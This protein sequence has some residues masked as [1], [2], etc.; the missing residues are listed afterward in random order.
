M[1][2]DIK[3][4]TINPKK[5][6]FKYF[7]GGRE[8]TDVNKIKYYKSLVIPPAWKDVSISSDPNKKILAIGLDDKFRKQYRY[9]KKYIQQQE[10]SKYKDR[11]IEFI[12]ELPYIRGGINKSLKKR[13]WDS[14]KVSAFV[15]NII[16]NCHLR[17][18]NDKYAKENDSYGITTLKGGHIDIKSNK[19]ILNFIGKKGVENY[20]EINEPSIIRLFKNYYN[21]F[22][23][24]QND[25]FFRYYGGNSGDEIFKINSSHINDYL[26]DYGDFSIKDFRTYSANEMLLKYYYNLYKFN[27]GLKDLSKNKLKQTN[28]KCIDKVSQHL[29]NTRAI[30]KKSYCSDYI[31][32]GF[33]D[34]PTEFITKVKKYM[35]KK[36][37]PYTG[38]QTALLNIFKDFKKEE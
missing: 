12:K 33:N 6:L 7:K 10:D 29:N 11:M 13:N 22:Q 14:E 25:D 19:I 5:H 3:R 2:L 16:D 31:I 20:S 36:V 26:K 15:I 23:P 4:K 34:N 30:C 18:G 17:V 8:I 9:N 35:K 21:E 24:K 28:N 37:E 32:G 27:G 38:L 1:E